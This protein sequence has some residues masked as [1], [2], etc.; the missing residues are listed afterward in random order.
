MFIPQLSDVLDRRTL[1]SGNAPLNDPSLP[2][3]FSLDT[4]GM[5]SFFGGEVAVTAMT[6]IHLDPTRRWLGWYNSP[7]T[8][9][10]ARRYGRVSDSKLL[11]G[12]FPGVPTDLATLLGLEGLKGTKYIGAHNG[13]I[14]E[15]TGPFSALLMKHSV[16]HLR[17]V[18]I[19]GR[20][21]QPIAVTITEL[22]H[23]P[24]NQAVLRTPIYPPIVAGIPILASVGTA[25]A[26]GVFQDWFSFSLIVFGI[27][28]NGVSCVVIGAGEFV[29]QYPN[30]RVDV[31][32]DG[33]LVSDK[34]KEIIVLM[35][36][37]D[38]VNSITLGSANL[39]FRWRYWIKW[40]AILLVLQLIV[41]I[42]LIP[43]G[44]LFGQIMFIGSLA[45]SWAYN[46][47][48]C[49]IDKE[50]IQGDVFVRGVLRS[51]RFWRYNLG[52]RTSAV[53]FMLL[54]LK[55]KDPGKILNMLIPNDTAEWLKFKD[56]ILSRIRTNQ[57]LRFE[58]SF[59]D[60]L[61]P[62]Q[63]R[64]LMELLYS[65]AEAAYKGYLNHLSRS[66]TKRTSL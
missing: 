66:A 27:L 16:D 28:V 62:E 25:V 44:T 29:F 17:T 58:T 5:A 42:L 31:P 10:V 2:Q 13:T 38:A 41:Q 49:S 65:D 24:N 48:L 23:P 54:T 53:V 11:E 26:C 6:T 36:S 60:T 64:E 14:L 56:D 35:G 55:P 21:T 1:Y 15:E 40:C 9:E 32:G 52:T 30:P 34:D 33:I 3:G 22:E 37:G 45:V 46:L 7:G 59:L 8:Y 63:D 39:R 47:W 61:A 43:Q 18:E 50:S 57:E 19:P 51:P 20:K 4:G 12:L